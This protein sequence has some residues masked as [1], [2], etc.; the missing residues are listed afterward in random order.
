[1]LT[2]AQMD[3]RVGAAALRTWRLLWWRVLTS[4]RFFR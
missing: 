4:G 2:I 3:P 1:M